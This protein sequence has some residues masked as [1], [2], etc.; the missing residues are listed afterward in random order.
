MI[1]KKGKVHRMLIN[2]YLKYNNINFK[3]INLFLYQ[4]IFSYDKINLNNIN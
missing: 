4:A 2:N 3:L 1:Y